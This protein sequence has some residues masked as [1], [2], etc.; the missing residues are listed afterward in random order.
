VDTEV[1]GHGVLALAAC[2]QE[3]FHLAG[4]LPV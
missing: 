2:G 3:R 1:I 4:A